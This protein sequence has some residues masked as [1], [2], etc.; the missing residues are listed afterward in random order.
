MCICIFVCVFIWARENEN[1]KPTQRWKDKVTA[2]LRAFGMKVTK[3]WLDSSRENK[4]SWRRKIFDGAKSYNDAKRNTAIEKRLQR[5]KK[6][7]NQRK[8]TGNFECGV[9]GCKKAFAQASSRNRHIRSH[10]PKAIN[11]KCPICPKVCS[12]QSGLTRHQR[13]HKEKDKA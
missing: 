6:E 12:N 1:K 9:D 3:W 7:T 8:P 4:A 11:L 2:D 13:I 10:H 5:K